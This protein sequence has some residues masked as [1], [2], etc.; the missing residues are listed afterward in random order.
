MA[1]Y[2]PQCFHTLIVTK[3]F[4][5]FGKTTNKGLVA[6]L[7]I[8]CNCIELKI[9]SI[10]ICPSILSTPRVT[11]SCIAK[12]TQI[13]VPT[14]VRPIR[15]TKYPSIGRHHVRYKSN[16]QLPYMILA[17]CVPN[18]MTVLSQRFLPKLL[19]ANSVYG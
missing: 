12:T 4:Y 3:P 16:S 7:G 15:T 10:H 17:A 11:N 13:V 6:H 9:E 1:K 8:T 19:H 2:G 18:G 14:C 5:G